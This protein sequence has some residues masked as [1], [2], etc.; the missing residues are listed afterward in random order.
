[1]KISIHQGEKRRHPRF[2][3]GIAMGIRADG[4]TV[5]KCRG[6]IA[7]LS[8]S[9]MTFKTNAVLEEGMCLYLRLDLPLEI[10]GEIRNMR[11]ATGGMLR[12]GV[13]FHRVRGE[14]Q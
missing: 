3:I 2:P 7:D 12:Y 14:S 4:Q 8:A 6:T 9:G 10:R 1:M 5:G 11:D 13:R